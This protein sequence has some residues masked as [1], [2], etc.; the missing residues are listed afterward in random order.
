M[1]YT[2]QRFKELYPDDDACLERI[3][4]N[5]YG[6]LEYCPKCAAKTKFYRVKKR[7]CYSCM[8]C[9][10]QLFPL[11]N[12]I[13]RSST[14]SLWSWFYAIYLF[15]VSKNGVSG[16]ELQRQLGV[17]YKTAWRMAKQIRL[18]MQEEGSSFGGPGKTVEVDGTFIGPKSSHQEFRSSKQ[19]VL[20]FAERGG[21]LK[22]RLA[23]ERSDILLPILRQEIATG[24]VV[25]TDGHRAYHHV[26]LDFEH[27]YIVHARRQFSKAGVNVNTVEGFIGQVKRSVSGTY[28]GIS[29]KYVGLYLNE[30]VYRYNHRTEAI[31]PLLLAKVGKLS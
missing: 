5:R 17:T 12:T 6:A 15:S 19:A 22:T 28:H 1:K 30:F 14:T 16:A 13:F 29:D 31:C 7:Q 25:Y 27:K 24:T 8:Y 20:T 11:S 10:K 23:T 2:I 18:L 3:F 26:S 21:Q 9:G 4:Q